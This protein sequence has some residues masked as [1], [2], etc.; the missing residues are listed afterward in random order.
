VSGTIGARGNNGV[1]VVGVDW[2]VKLLPLRFI[3]QTS[4][5]TFDA[6][7]CID[8]AIKLK[9]Q[10]VNIR[11]LNNSWG[12]GP[13]SPSLYQ[14]IVRANTA[15]ILFVCA[16]GNESAD[17]D[18][19]PHFPSS[20]EVPNVV[21]VGALTAAGIVAGFSNY[22][23][24]S[25]D[26]FA[27]GDN[28][29]S[30]LPDNTYGTLSGTS[31]ASPHVAGTAGLIA[32]AYPTATPAEIKARLLGSCDSSSSL[33]TACL[34]QGSISALRALRQDSTPPGRIAD[35]H[36]TSIGQSTI[37][38]AW[39]AVGDDG[40][41]GRAIYYDIRWAESPITS[42]SFSSAFQIPDSRVPLGAGQDE[43]ATVRGCFTSGGPLFVA[44]RVYDR[45]GN[46]SQTASLTAQPTG[47]PIVYSVVPATDPGFSLGTPLNLKYDDRATGVD[48]DFD[49]PFFGTTYR[50]AYVS[51]NGLIAFD[52]PIASPT[53]TA[54]DLKTQTAIAPLWFDLRTDGK[55]VQNED[56]Y[57]T[58]GA[59]SITFR[60]LAEMY[61]EPGAA[62]KDQQP[63]TFAATLHED[64][65]VD[66]VYGPGGNR[67]L[68][69]DG[70]VPVV[71][72][73]DG[74]C[75]SKVVDGYSGR[76]Q[77][78][79]A[80]AVSF[81]PGAQGAG[82]APT[83][84]VPSLAAATESYPYEFTVTAADAEG[85]PVTL[86]ASLPRNATLDASTG[87]VTFTPD[88]AQGGGVVQFVFSATNAAGITATKS[89]AMGVQNYSLLPEVTYLTFKKKV[90]FNGGGFKP[91]TKLEI[92]GQVIA[93]ARATK[94]TKITSVAAA[95]ILTQ[96]GVHT[97]VVVNPDGFRSGPYFSI[98]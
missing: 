53:G 19:T 55:L 69:A 62:P 37:N 57:V 82:S 68:S 81:R 29:L 42:E 96:P 2:N 74:G 43:A 98:R 77:L 73:A 18:E 6:I 95:A 46:F 78:T 38:V 87:K 32:A 83:L 20:Y 27:P 34:L 76:N 70:A 92:D 24:K 58:R 22:G 75:T 64:G 17:N 48:L 39:K 51:T 36:V 79:N 56:V 11:V 3:T 25:V 23:K 26:V 60:W 59:S 5:S 28:I 49:F 40:A 4:G 33:S 86:S 45:A 71:G 84:T 15:G 93:D 90:T 35:F 41:T 89:V 10:G 7:E 61:Y 13:F 50:T 16:A 14:A 8:Y 31:M 44:M 47:S 85:G 1:G 66:F 52:G 63:V 21:S 97:V 67:E 30:T 88:S 65:T 94:A 54:N 12:G 91:A 80:P 72:V 9:S